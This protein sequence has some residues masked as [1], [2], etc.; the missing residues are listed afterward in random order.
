MWSKLVRKFIVFALRN[1]A[2][3]T[4]D[5][6]AC[7]AALLENMHALPLQNKMS[8]NEQGTLVI[9]GSPVEY[10]VAAKLRESAKAMLD[11]YARKLVM[12]QVTFMAVNLGI[13]QGTSPEQILFAKA[14]LWHGQEE[15]KLYRALAQ[16]E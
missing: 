10:A 5:K 8:F 15:E 9:S 7:V 6:S 13:H 3:S 14:A 16:Q 1:I 11:S 4:Q 2:L 12:E